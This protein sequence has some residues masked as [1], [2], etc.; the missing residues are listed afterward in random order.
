MTISIEAIASSET[1]RNL[2]QSNRAT[3]L[4]WARS[5][6]LGAP[7]SI[8]DLLATFESLHFARPNPTRLRAILSKSRSVRKSGID[9]FLPIRHFMDE[10]E[11]V[12]SFA[13]EIERQFQQDSLVRPPFAR[14]E[15]IDGLGMMIEF[16]SHLFLLENSIRG[17]VEDRMIKSHG[18]SWWETVASTSMKKKHTDRMD[19]ELQNKWA[20]T[21]SEFGPLYSID[22]PDLITI[23]RKEHSSFLDKIPDIGF[24]HRFEDLGHYRN[25][26]AHHGVLDDPN[27]IG[28]I[29]IY[30]SDWI[31]Q[32]S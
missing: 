2:D 15:A 32:I 25:I 9:S 24:M 21:R 31:K 4:V 8:A 5:K 22:W 16:Y 27:A 10:C 7:V 1:F 13:L 11:A 12:Y 14:K 26:V 19:R 28:R 17:F 23:I 20:P 29:R 18:K 6:L 30:Y 3:V